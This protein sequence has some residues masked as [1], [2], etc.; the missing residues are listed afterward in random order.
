MS[1]VRHGYQ[2]DNMWSDD[3]FRESKGKTLKSIM[4]SHDG[5]NFSGFV[6]SDPK[7]EEITSQLPN[8]H[9]TLTSHMLDPE[10]LNNHESTRLVGFRTTKRCKSSKQVMSVQP[11]YFSVK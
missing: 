5:G 11:I 9:I 10:I 4:T 7:S 2:F 3:F 1:P 8:E 6:L